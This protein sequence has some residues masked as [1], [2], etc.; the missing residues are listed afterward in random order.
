M[1]NS[2]GDSELPGG[3]LPG[4]ANIPN[5]SL[6]P[7]IRHSG[8]VFAVLLTLFFFCRQYVFEAALDRGLIY[9]RTWP[10]LNPRQKRGFVNHHLSFVAK[11]FVLLFAIYPFFAVA[12]GHADFRTPMF[13]RSVGF[14][15]RDYGFTM[16]DA[17]YLA[18][19]IVSVMYAHE[20]AY[21]EGISPVA[22]AHHV[23]V[24]VM[25]QL[26]LYWS[27]SNK[28]QPDAALE[29]VLALFWGFYDLV[30][31]VPPHITMIIYRDPD[32]AQ[33]TL[34]RSFSVAFWCSLVG[35]V[36]ETA[37][38]FGLYGA[39][40]NKWTL[41]MKVMIPILHCIFTAAQLWGEYC[42][43][44][45]WQQEKGKAKR[46]QVDGNESLRSENGKVKAD[47]E[48][49]GKDG[50]TVNSIEIAPV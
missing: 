27:A 32:V 25:G 3:A 13:G 43:W 7:M 2:M 33:K 11:I 34:M 29:A 8:L 15:R 38:I 4:F 42:T 47:D 16:G 6:S 22:V 31:E 35:T 48:A 49:E 36:A 23:G 45:L 14:S 10:T 21:R 28:G 18:I 30:V 19:M 26:T 24:L 39:L 44:S 41:T 12:T 20:L 37:T 50:K 9:K 1:S 46:V 5:V 40:W 17:L